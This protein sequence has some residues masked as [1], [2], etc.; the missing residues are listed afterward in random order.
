MAQDVAWLRRRFSDD[1]GDVHM[2]TLTRHLGQGVNR[3]TQMVNTRW[4]FE[5]FEKR[6]KV[7]AK[8]IDLHNLSLADSANSVISGSDA[9]RDALGDTSKISVL[10]VPDIAYK[11]AD[12]SEQANMIPIQQGLF[13]GETGP[14]LRT[15]GA[16]QKVQNLSP[17]EVVERHLGSRMAQDALYKKLGENGILDWVPDGICLSKLESS[18]EDATNHIFDAQA[19]QLYNVGVQGPCTTTTWSGSPKLQCMPM[20]KVFIV[21]IARVDVE[22]S[23]GGLT[24]LHSARKRMGD[25]NLDDADKLKDVNVGHFRHKEAADRKKYDKGPDDLTPDLERDILF[26]AALLLRKG[27]TGAN[28]VL[29][30]FRLE[31][32][33]S[34]F[35]AAYSLDKPGTNLSRCGLAKTTIRGGNKDDV[36]AIEYSTEYIVGG[37]C[38]GTVLDTAASRATEWNV[39][40]AAPASMPLNVHVDVSWWS[41]DDLYQHYQNRSRGPLDYKD[42][43]IGVEGAYDG[44]SFS[45]SMAALAKIDEGALTPYAKDQIQ[46]REKGGV[47]RP[48]AGTSLDTDSWIEDDAPVQPSA[49]FEY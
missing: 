29:S 28:A 6:F 46:K 22:L 11:M 38:I 15:Y 43:S 4:L 9:V 13:V 36:A 26:Q 27:L 39:V 24:P 17:G 12:A 40:R 33:T 20:D 37:W 42:D 2:E 10:H 1:G 23:T 21:V 35:L 48:R 25:Y 32:M 18:G 49:R 34:S 14:F 8:R 47:K 5:N 19:G 44:T 41:G 30:K 31:K 16:D 45:R 3:F 7:D